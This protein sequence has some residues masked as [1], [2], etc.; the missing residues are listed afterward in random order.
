MSREL[1]TN[2]RSINLILSF[3][4]FLARCGINE[5]LTLLFNPLILFP[6][7]FTDIEPKFQFS[8]KIIQKKQ[9]KQNE[10]LTTTNYQTTRHVLIN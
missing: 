1:Y 7:L 5:N 9:E 2:K 8:R 6:R 10:T 3:V 4:T